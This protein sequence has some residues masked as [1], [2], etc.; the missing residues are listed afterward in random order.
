MN[1]RSDIY[2]LEDIKKVSRLMSEKKLSPSLPMAA[3]AK[4]IKGEFPNCPPSTLL[5][6]VKMVYRFSDETLELAEDGKITKTMIATVRDMEFGNPSY[7]DL[8]A[9]ASVD[10]PFTVKHLPEI[11]TLTRKGRHPIEAIKM[12]LSGKASRKVPTKSDALSLDVIFKEFE[13]DGFAWR[14]RAILLKGMGKFQVLKDG[15]LNNRLAYTLAAMKTAVDDM[16][17]FVDEMWEGVPE[18][19]QKAVSEMMDDEPRKPDEGLFALPP[20]ESAEEDPGNEPQDEVPDASLSER[21][22]VGETER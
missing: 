10:Y 18:D 4:E 3:V 13:K 17:R 14:Q 11:R 16:K 21:H 9:R 22:A 2:T 7:Q 1:L 8:I 19:V 12:V 6:W 20:P 15:S 5:R